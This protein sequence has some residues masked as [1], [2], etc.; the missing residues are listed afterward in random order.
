MNSILNISGLYE[1]ESWSPSEPCVKVG[2]RDLEGCCC[3]CDGAARE[4]LRGEVRKLD[5]NALHWIDSGDYHY[6]TLFFLERIEEPFDLV[7]LDNH[8]DDQEPAFGDGLLSCGGWV[9]GAR[10]TLPLLRDVLRNPSES[11][12]AGTAEGCACR[13]PVYL[14]ID[15]DVLS[16]DF[17]RTDW[18]QGDMT[19]EQL[20]SA[21]KSLRASRRLLGVDV[22]G[23]LAINKGACPEDLLVN[24]RTRDMIQSLF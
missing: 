17:A 15:I 21:V 1:D 16:R 18:S 6:I 13:R 11:D 8:P 9:A 5:L 20:Y 12:L 24:R 22:C 14:S 23:G 10:R 3:Y 19:L 7:L 4:R 2:L